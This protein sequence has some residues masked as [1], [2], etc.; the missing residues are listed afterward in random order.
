M[1]AEFPPNSPTPTASIA[2]ASVATASVATASIATASIASTGIPSA[3]IGDRWSE[4][5]GGICAVGGGIGRIG[6]HDCASRA[7]REDGS[8]IAEVVCHRWGGILGDGT[9]PGSDR[10]RNLRADGGRG[11]VVVGHRVPLVAVIDT[12]C[13]VLRMHLHRA[14]RAAGHIA[15][16]A[17][18]GEG[19]REQALIMIPMPPLWDDDGWRV[20][21]GRAGRTGTGLRGRQSRGSI[22]HRKGRGEISGGIRRPAAGN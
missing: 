11:L 12:P 13:A 14:G 7:H 22:G 10:P 8:R 3:S 6:P 4:S 9:V 15:N 16:G 20:E 19:S 18:G 1:I 2:T 17:G 5:Q 21:S